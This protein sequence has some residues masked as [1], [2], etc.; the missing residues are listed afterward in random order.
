MPDPFK[1]ERFLALSTADQVR[2]LGELNK[3]F[4]ELDEEQKLELLQRGLSG[5]VRETEDK[6]LMARAVGALRSG[7][8]VADQFAAGVFDSIDATEEFLRSGARKLGVPLPEADVLGAV[9][10]EAAAPSTGA[11]RTARNIG[12]TTGE[13]LQIGALPAAGALKAV[14]GVA[15]ALRLPGTQAARAIQASKGAPSVTRQ[16]VRQ[17]TTEPFERAPGAAA[18]TELGAA[19]GA[20]AGEEA[21]GPVGA[22]A[23]GLLG[24]LP[25]AVKVGQAIR[26]Q[27]AAAAPAPQAPAGPPIKKPRVT[28]EEAQAAARKV[29]EGKP[30]RTPGEPDSPL[31]GLGEQAATTQSRK[32]LANMQGELDDLP[33]RAQNVLLSKFESVEGPDDFRRVLA[34]TAEI[35]AKRIS[36]ARARGVTSGDIEILEQRLGIE[37]GS[38]AEVFGP[39]MTPDQIQQIRTLTA[40]SAKE[41]LSDGQSIAARLARGE[42]VREQEYAKFAKAWQRHVAIQEVLSG[43]TATSGR[44]LRAFREAVQA[45]RT[46]QEVIAGFGGKGRIGELAQMMAQL[47]EEGSEEAF[48]KLII[49]GANPTL[50]GKGLELFFASIL[51]GTGTQFVNI[52]GNA[53]FLAIDMLEEAIGS[54]VT[55]PV[56]RRAFRER[57]KGTAKALPAAVRRGREAF[58]S[59]V[60]ADVP[61]AVEISRPPQ[62]GGRTGRIVR[63]PMRALQS[64]DG[65]FKQLGETGELYGESARQAFDELGHL[66][67]GAHGLALSKKSVELSIGKRIQELISNPTKELLEKVEKRG[68]ELTF[69]RRL[70]KGLR[71]LETLRDPE[72]SGTVASTIGQVLLPFVRTPTN[73]LIQ[74]LKRTPPAALVD[75]F[76][77]SGQ[78]RTRALGRLAIGMGVFGSAWKMAEAGLITGAAPTD[79]GERSVFFEDEKKLPYAIKIGGT[80]HQYNRFDPF[81]TL[82]G[83]TADFVLEIQDPDSEGASERIGNAFDRFLALSIDKPYMQGLRRFA[84]AREPDDL[85][86]ALVQTLVNPLVP[87]LIAQVARTG[88]PGGRQ[89]EGALGLE[90]GTLGRDRAVRESRAGGPALET[91]LAPL[92]SRIPG[93][94]QRLPARVGITGEPLEANIEGLIPGGPARRTAERTPVPSAFAAA[95]VGVSRMKRDLKLPGKQG[96]VTLTNREVIEMETD[97]GRQLARIVGR[98]AESETFRKL[99]KSIRERFLR[100]ALDQANGLARRRATLKKMRERR[101]AKK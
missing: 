53:G 95:G 98:R 82:L 16:I 70:P 75:A 26:R 38:L 93:L 63:I 100:R 99:P 37:K 42:S 9:G 4:A 73:I 83:A 55:G 85:T 67:T 39:S 41:I 12:E 86:R 25:G 10:I 79:A 54:L 68:R 33:D 34:E 3:G 59:G 51:S 47:G 62:I 57:V 48:S 92:Q 28:L 11:Q 76:K 50:V 58:K 97:R 20:G 46:V 23:G 19:V 14:P 2:M 6:S 36:A 65:F 81:G 17:I 64:M 61:T 80:W 77:S 94:R 60:G 87:N 96:E 52:V 84:Y 56:A 1:N 49:G 31:T 32:L 13:A 22:I 35:N 45:G 8:E 40:T 90:E 44:N 72:K 18:A 101:K 88:L 29:R 71:A 78:E 66:R 89:I 7:I 69:Q 30:T 15:R 27:T 43:V 91:I 21:G 74:G 5:T 24:G